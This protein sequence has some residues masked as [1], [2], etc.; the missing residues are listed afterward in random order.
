MQSFGEVR[1]SWCM[2]G[3]SGGGEGDDDA[4]MSPMAIAQMTCDE[5][6]EEVNEK[7]FPTDDVSRGMNEEDKGPY[8]FVFLQ[9]CEYMNALLYE[10][11]KGLQETGWIFSSE[12]TRSCRWTRFKRIIEGSRYL[13]FTLECWCQRSSSKQWLCFVGGSQ[14]LEFSFKNL[15]YLWIKITPLDQ[16]K[17]GWKSHFYKKSTL[18]KTNIAPENRLS[19]KESSIPTIHLQV[20]C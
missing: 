10:M 2:P 1:I 3:G 15:M 8:Q 18:P 11:V 17:V 4:A 14:N 6:L 12:I 9:E 13:L 5:I 19:Q 20:L 7:K 16:P